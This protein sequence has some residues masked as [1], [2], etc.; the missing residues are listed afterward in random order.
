ML[1]S[2]ALIFQ[3]EQLHRE[4]G[5]SRQLKQDQEES[6]QLRKDHKPICP[7]HVNWKTK[8]LILS[9]LLII[10]GS[11]DSEEPFTEGNN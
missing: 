11:K 8:F 1:S 4:L 7:A 6:C 5:E 2:R 10:I 3:H 9:L